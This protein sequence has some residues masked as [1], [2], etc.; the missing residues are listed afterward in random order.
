MRALNSVSSLI[1]LGTTK[2]NKEER[3]SKAGNLKSEIRN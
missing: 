3:R 1:I 2:I